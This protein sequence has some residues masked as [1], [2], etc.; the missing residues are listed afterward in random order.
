MC[1]TTGLQLASA[2]REEDTRINQDDT[3][4]TGHMS[5]LSAS[6]QMMVLR[7]TKARQVQRA[8]IKRRE[9]AK[10]K[11][12]S[13]YRI[14]QLS[15]TMLYSHPL[16]GG[17][18]TARKLADEENYDRFFS[19]FQKK[20]GR[21]LTHTNKNWICKVLSQGRTWKIEK[22]LRENIGPNNKM[23]KQIFG[24]QFPPP[25]TWW[26]PKSYAQGILENC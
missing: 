4:S 9:G 24:P 2:S 11:A 16:R 21:Q 20:G 26:V 13:K 3:Q 10:N 23:A 25:Q 5:A 6:S 12:I 1:W 7:S 15:E 14:I 8:D 22:R 18:D 17:V 19:S